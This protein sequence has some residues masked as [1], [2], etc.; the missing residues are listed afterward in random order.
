MTLERML[1]QLRDS[2]G[3]QAAAVVSRDGL[4][5]A[6]D[7]PDNISKETFAIMCATILGAGMT[8]A[9][10]LRYSAP[11]HV[12]LSTREARIHIFEAGPRALVV[13]VAPPNRDEEEIRAA[14]QPVMEEVRREIG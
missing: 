2:C 1:R 11:S 12:S 5:I 10:E 3:S 8:A 4:V 13:L 9:T 6:G 7:M 14:L